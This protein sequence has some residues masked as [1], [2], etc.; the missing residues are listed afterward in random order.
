[1]NKSLSSQSINITMTLLYFLL[2]DLVH[3]DVMIVV[4][5]S[6][7][8]GAKVFFFERDFGAKVSGIL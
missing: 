1:M 4:G 5:A 7:I 2:N 3:Y 8:F 6:S